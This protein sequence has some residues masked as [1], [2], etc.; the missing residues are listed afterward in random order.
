MNIHEFIELHLSDDPFFMELYH[1]NPR[2]EGY[3]ANLLHH[4][5]Y[6]FASCVDLNDTLD[7]AN[8]LYRSARTVARLWFKDGAL[9]TALDRDWQEYVRV[10]EARRSQGNSRYFDDGS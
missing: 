8:S 1:E 4:M 9:V 10:Y 2:D 3:I 7:S 6:S 5:C